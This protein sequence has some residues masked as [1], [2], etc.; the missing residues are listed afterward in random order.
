LPCCGLRLPG[1]GSPLPKDPRSGW[2]PC[3]G[4]ARRVTICGRTGKVIGIIEGCSLPRFR[5]GLGGAADRIGIVARGR[6]LSNGR[7]GRRPV[8]PLSFFG[9][10]S[11]VAFLARD[12]VDRMVREARRRSSLPGRRG[13]EIGRR[14]EARLVVRQMR[15]WSIETDRGRG[16]VRLIAARRWGW[17]LPLAGFHRGVPQQRRERSPRGRLVFGQSLGSREEKQQRRTG[18]Q[19]E[20]SASPTRPPSIEPARHFSYADLRPPQ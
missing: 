10:D 11:V 14:V 3:I 12:C 4:I 18:H 6:K 5:R 15:L 9:N 7:L 2:A 19:V 13:T 1:Q 17:H 8:P 16:R 20:P